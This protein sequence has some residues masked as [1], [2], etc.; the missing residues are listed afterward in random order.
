MT[1]RAILCATLL[2]ALAAP[3]CAWAKADVL[4]DSP[5]AG[6]DGAASV[7]AW[8]QD[9][10]ARELPFSVL[11]L[12][13]LPALP[14]LA[15]PGAAQ[16]GRAQGRQA[17][18]TAHVTFE[19]D[20]QVDLYAS[21]A[22]GYKASSVNIARGSRPFGVEQAFAEVAGLAGS[23]QSYGARF[24]RPEDTKVYEIG[25]R[26]D[27]GVADFNLAL[28]QQSTTGTQSSMLVGSN[29][30]LA[31]VGRETVRGAEIEASLR[32]ARGLVVSAAVT[33]LDARYESYAVSAAG[34]LL[35][36]RPAG[37]PALSATVGAAR[38]WPLAGG[39]RLILRG[40]FHYESSTQIQQA[41][42][43][44]SGFSGSAAHPAFVLATQEF[45]SPGLDRLLVSSAQRA[46]SIAGSLP[47]AAPFRAGVSEV[48]T[49][50]TW[51]VRSGLDFTVWGRNI[52]NN[53]YRVTLLD[54][55]GLPT[56]AWG[57]ANQPQSFGGTVRARF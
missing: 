20:G 8:E 32:P 37:I 33:Y 48:G 2:C 56:T 54:A 57:Y 16:P 18:W 50:L 30:M 22:T 7:R 31:Q 3:Q 27:W 29:F 49:S 5:F 52:A 51:A 38:Q 35:N 25:M 13:V 46:S 42:P 15:L 53:R 6:G 40:N 34:D 28:F 36:M 43:G 10:L 44:V 11:P 24:A 23:N 47:F 17:K 41:L 45:A 26:A 14:L 1:V 4:A 9:T 21:F 39:G 12:P 55:D 19:L